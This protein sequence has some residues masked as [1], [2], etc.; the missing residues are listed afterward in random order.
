MFQDLLPIALSGEGEISI[1]SVIEGSWNRLRLGTIVRARNS[2]LRYG[3][4]LRK[5][6]GT[7]AEWSSRISR[8]ENRFVIHESLLTLG[9]SRINLSGVYEHGSR[10]RLQ[11][12]ARS[13][14]SD[15]SEVIELF[16]AVRGFRA[17][18]NLHGEVLAS[19]LLIGN[20]A[21]NMNGKL[22]ISEAEL[23]HETSS[24]KLERLSASLLLLGKQAR[25][26]DAA[27]RVR[28]S[29]IEMKGAV[30][31]LAIP[32]LNLELSSANLHLVDLADFQVA[33]SD[34]LQN[35]RLI[36]KVQ[37]ENGTPSFRGMV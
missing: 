24:R 34:R 18:G 25:I 28:S 27:F 8:Q 23:S 14:R 22:E 2:E 3:T 30:A 15:L 26:E 12:R 1:E 17:T 4:W 7:A 19:K 9:S 35:V 11:L 10:A 13:D 21:W 20:S 5:P 6:R 37:L 31:D 33:K 36:G 16:P 29:D 32:A